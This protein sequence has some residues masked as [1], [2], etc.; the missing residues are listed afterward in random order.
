M[1][2]YI[3]IV[4]AAAGFVM[5]LTGKI[6]PGLKASRGKPKITATLPDGSRLTFDA[7]EDEVSHLRA[8]NQKQAEESHVA[9]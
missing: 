9:I 8:L 6:V 1:M 7:S 2:A 3:A 5:A 4:A